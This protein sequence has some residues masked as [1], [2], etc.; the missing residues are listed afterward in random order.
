LLICNW[1]SSRRLKLADKRSEES[2]PLAQKH[3]D[4]PTSSNPGV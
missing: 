3:H 4:T 2:T 1:Q